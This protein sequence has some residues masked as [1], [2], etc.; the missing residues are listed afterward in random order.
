MENTIPFLFGVFVG[1]IIGIGLAH[2]WIQLE[3]PTEARDVRR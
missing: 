3:D 2:A 1:L